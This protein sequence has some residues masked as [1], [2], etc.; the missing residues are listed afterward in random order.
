MSKIWLEP[1]KT[2][3]TCHILE[4][5]NVMTPRI[6]SGVMRRIKAAPTKPLRQVA[7]EAGLNRESVRLVVKEEG[8]KSLRRTKV[9]LVSALGLQKRQERSQG[10]INNLKSARQGRIIFFSDEKNF[11]IDP[12][13]NP[14]NDRWIR[15]F[16]QEEDDQE[17]GHQHA[18][19]TKKSKFVARSKHPASVMFLGAVAST[20]ETS[21]PI[22]FP[23]GFRLGADDYIKALKDTLIPWMRRVAA[24]HGNAP[25]VFQQDSAPAHR[26]KKTLEFLK[27]EN[28]NFWSPEEWP[29][30]SPDL[31]PLDY[32]I[33]STVSQKACKERQPS[34]L[35][36]KR[37]VGSYWRRMPPQDVR[38]ACRR[39]RP[40]LERCVAENGSYFD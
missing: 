6:R 22:W 21:P 40:R 29:P 11:V 9:P 15:I 33:W 17:P 39:F 37:K 32:S 27:G 20:G 30:N 34:I 2:L 19:D 24:A 16:D 26:A 14:Q 3:D 28:I 8:W 35:A 13:Y 23:Q 5:K 38:A 18:K 31:N 36:L 1:G 4:K 25:F 12:V 10:L 7:Q